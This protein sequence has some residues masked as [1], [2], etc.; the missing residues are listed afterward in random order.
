MVGCR[1]KNRQTWYITNNA[2]CTTT[3]WHGSHNNLARDQQITLTLL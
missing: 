3:S 1:S 2:L